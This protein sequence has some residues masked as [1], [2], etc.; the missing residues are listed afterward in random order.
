VPSAKE[1]L[2]KYNSE[3]CAALELVFPA[4]S[5][6]CQNHVASDMGCRHLRPD[7]PPAV[8]DHASSFLHPHLT[9]DKVYFIASV[10]TCPR[11]AS[12]S[13]LG[14]RRQLI[15]W[16]LPQGES[17]ELVIPIRWRLRRAYF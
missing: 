10:T 9:C 16:R 15:M 4:I 11:G 7:L 8:I 6:A 2:I 5:Q 14:R 17:K 3:D 13:T 12:K 1:T